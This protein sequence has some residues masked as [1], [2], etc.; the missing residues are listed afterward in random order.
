VKDQ[1]FCC[2]PAVVVFW[3]SWLPATS[4]TPVVITPLYLVPLAKCVVVDV[5]KGLS[6]A[7]LVVGRS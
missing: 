1:A 7:V 6:V 5:P 3:S 4:F 2:K